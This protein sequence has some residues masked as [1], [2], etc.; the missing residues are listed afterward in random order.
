MQVVVE[1]GRTVEPGDLNVKLIIASI[2]LAAGQVSRILCVGHNTLALSFAT[3]TFGQMELDTPGVFWSTMPGWEQQCST[4]PLQGV[5]QPPRLLLPT[6]AP[7]PSSLIRWV[8][9]S[10]HNVIPQA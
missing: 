2:S 5:L 7:S 1:G 4:A 6:A 10:S 8:C 3:A 9:L